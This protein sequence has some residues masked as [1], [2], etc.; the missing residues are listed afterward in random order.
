MKSTGC[1][2][3]RVV[4]KIT[5]KYRF[6]IPRLEDILDKLEASSVFSKLYKRSGYHQIRINLGMSGKQPLKLGK[7]FMNS[8]SCPLVCA[9][10]LVP[11]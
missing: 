5:I 2:N 8:K 1:M 10:P 11:S 4:N 9:I 6:P 3:G 7:G